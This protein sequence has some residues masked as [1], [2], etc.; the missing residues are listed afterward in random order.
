MAA[1]ADP[2]GKPPANT[3]DGLSSPALK[4]WVPHRILRCPSVDRHID[5]VTVAGGDR[6]R[7]STPSP[8]ETGDDE[9]LEALRAKLMGHLREAADRLKLPAA[10]EPPAL[11]PPAEKEKEKEPEPSSSAAARPWNLRTRRRQ[12]MPYSAE[13]PTDGAVAMARERREREKERPRFSISLTAEEIEEDIY[14]ITGSRPRRRPKK[15]PKIVQ[16]QL[17]SI[18]PGL[19]L[20]EITADSYKVEDE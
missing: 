16:R 1:A 18:F 19:W 8:D 11:P 13:A 9:G 15:R 14:A 2:R 3:L 10:P 20:S 12:T 4:P 6:S 7:R 5:A 17:D